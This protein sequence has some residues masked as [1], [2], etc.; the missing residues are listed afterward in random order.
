M[1]RPVSVGL[2]LR[3]RDGAY[4]AVL[5]GR[6]RRPH[7]LLCRMVFQARRGPGF[8]EHR[9][10]VEQSLRAGI[11]THG[12]NPMAVEVMKEDGIDISHHTSNNVNEYKTI[13]FD[14]I[15]TVCDNAKENCPYF[16]SSAKMFHENFADPAKATGTKE[17]IKNSFIDVRNKIKSYL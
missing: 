3:G 14:Y 11:E 8:R 5:F 10:P 6:Y 12:V 9:L 7:P 2:E 17:E 1:D 4:A 13:N 15:I 16:P